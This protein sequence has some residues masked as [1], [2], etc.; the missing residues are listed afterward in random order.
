VQNYGI[1]RVTRT[2]AIRQLV[3]SRN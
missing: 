2:Y 1:N 3:S